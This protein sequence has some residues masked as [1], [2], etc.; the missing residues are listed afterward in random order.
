VVIATLMA[1]SSVALAG[2][3]QY[4]SYK[5]LFPDITYSGS[6]GS[7]HWEKPWFEVGENDGPGAGMVR[8]YTG[9][10]YDHKCLI[11][12]GRGD[13]GTLGAQ[14][15]ADLSFFEDADLC[16]DV[17]AQLEGEEDLSEGE[18]WV[19]VT[20][21]GETWKTVDS[22]NL[23]HLDGNARHRQKGLNNYLT[24]GFGVRFIV[25][26]TLVGEVYVDNVEIKGQFGGAS[27]TTSTKTTSTT[28]TTEP[29]Q[30]TSTITTTGGPETTT[31]GATA[32]ATA[33]TTSTTFAQTT[34]TSVA[35]LVPVDPLEPP[36]NTGL[37]LTDFGVQAGYS[38]DW[39]GAMD[40]GTSDVLSVG[41]EANY[42]TAVEVFST[43]WIWMVALLLIIAVAIV[44]GLDRR[45]PDKGSAAT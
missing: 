4:E 32:I 18:L 31:T 12:E 28:S 17:V 13:V 1:V 9:G 11:I 36:S 5:D 7:V 27:A 42:S 33:D 43:T 40:M 21:D 44:T 2:T 30:T 6:A 24:D 22:F 20:S 3:E 38:P 16:F 39:F 10:C 41:L 19:Q 37:R 45:R 25:T 15:Y 8:V 35:A 29:N 26:G 34:T 23:Q 14:R